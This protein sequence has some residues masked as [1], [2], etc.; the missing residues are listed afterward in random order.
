MAGAA[1]F[2]NMFMAGAALPTH[3][4]SW[5]ALLTLEHCSWLVLDPDSCVTGV[6]GA[7]LRLCTQYAP[8]MMQ[9]GFAQQL[10]AFCIAVAVHN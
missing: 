3:T 6:S 2:V 7:Y 5:L 8:M 10:V 1:L 4:Y 9:Q